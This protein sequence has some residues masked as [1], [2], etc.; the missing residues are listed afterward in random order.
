MN[1]G[2]NLNKLDSGMGGAQSSIIENGRQ[3]PAGAGTE[4]GHALPV[5]EAGPP[6]GAPHW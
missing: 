2:E 1:D 6:G 3:D 5:E 4:L